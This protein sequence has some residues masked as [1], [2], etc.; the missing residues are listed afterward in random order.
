MK[1]WLHVIG[2]GENGLDDLPP[3][4]HPLI[5]EAEFIVGGRRHL[6][7]I[8]RQHALEHEW[9]NPLSHSIAEILRWRNRRVVVLA[10]G[11]PMNFGIGSVLARHIPIDEMKIHP[12][13]SAFSLAA[14]A[15]GWNL[16][17]VAC[18]SAHNRPMT[19]LSRELLPGRKLLVLTEDGMSAASCSK[20]LCE[21]G[22][23]NSRMHV[24]E[25]LGGPKERYFNSIARQWPHD[26]GV[27]DLNILG[28]ECE[29]DG[30]GMA[31]SHAPGLP[32]DCYCHDGKITKAE[33][34]ALTVSALQPMP[35]ELLWDV[36]AGCGSVAI[37]WVRH[38][39]LMQAIAIEQDEAK[40]HFI[41]KNAKVMGVPELR[42]VAGK[43]P[44]VLHDLPRPHAI[45]IGGGAHTHHLID[46]CW[47]SLLPG[48]RI[49]LNA[50]TTSAEG[51]AIAAFEKFGGEMV[52]LQIQRLAPVGR[53][54]GWKPLMPV[55]QWRAVKA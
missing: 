42:I 44:E 1:P 32:D 10:S 23:G 46:Y 31:F 26:Q 45:F 34:R 21:M 16:A 38:H 3:R 8:G 5:A 41:A 20:W 35:G 2:I 54:K 9:H 15:L 40:L 50:V 49:V 33:I 13:C 25:H 39:R 27:A 28:I 36:G 48:G 12:S 43:A 22:Y 37:E 14:A 11:D 47:E 4:L 17:E 6:D 30:S 18:L 29:L 53:F 52:R 55:T 24:F 19:S 7:L 51:I